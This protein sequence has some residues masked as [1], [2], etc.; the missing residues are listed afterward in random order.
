MYIKWIKD[1]KNVEVYKILALLLISLKK[2]IMYKL[3][4]GLT[5]Y[6]YK[7]PHNNSKVA[8]INLKNQ[9]QRSAFIRQNMRYLAVTLFQNMYIYI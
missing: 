6:W 4:F 8:I 5:C 3:P 9:K 1:W 2:Y 7:F